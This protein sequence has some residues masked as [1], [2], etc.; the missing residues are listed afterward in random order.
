MTDENT[1]PAVDTPV[2]DAPVAEA[3]KP[4]TVAP[5]VDADSLAKMQKRIDRL[6]WELRERDKQARP[7][8]QTPASETPKAP[9]RSDEG[10]DYDDDK[11]HAAVLEYSKAVARQEARE[12]LRA[13]RE[14]MTAQEKREA[15]D[16]RQD[17]FIKSKPD[18]RE[19]V[20]MN[21]HID[22]T[23]A[24][25]LVDGQIDPEVIYALAEDEEKLIAIAKL[26][27][28]L[29]AREIG[30]IEARLEAAKLTP[31]PSPKA[32]NAPPPVPKIDA[33]DPVVTKDPAN[34]TDKEFAKW[35]RNQIAQRR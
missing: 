32:S 30:R 33:V 4:E 8:S 34:M 27:P 2:A 5:R 7:E 11:Y 18:Y 26:S 15:F 12:A 31:P 25:T 10:I 21:P 6:T 17:E 28:F 22:D 13:E 9:K 35:R 3:P 24:K 23:L 1:A 14:Q 16:K 29:Q 19:K 20:W